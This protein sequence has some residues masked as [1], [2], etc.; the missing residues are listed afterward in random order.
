MTGNFVKIGDAVLSR[1][2][3]GKDYVDRKFAEAT[4][5][6]TGATGST[7][8]VKGLVPAP[9]AGDED[10]VLSGAGTWVPMSGGSS[11]DLSVIAPGYVEGSSYNRGQLVH[12]D[13]KLYRAPGPVSDDSWVAEH[14]AEVRVSDVVPSVIQS[15]SV[16]EASFTS[17]MVAMEDGDSVTVAFVPE[18]GNMG[19]LVAGSAI[20]ARKIVPANAGKTLAVNREGTGMELTPVLP[21][22]PV[23]GAT[24]GRKNGEWKAVVDVIPNTT[25]EPFVL[26]LDSNNRWMKQRVYG[27]FRDPIYSPFPVLDTLVSSDDRLYYY[28]GVL[29]VASNTNDGRYNLADS[30]GHTFNFI[31]ER[32]TGVAVLNGLLYVS[33]CTTTG[34]SGS[35]DCHLYEMSR[36]FTSCTSLYTQHNDSVS[37]S[38]GLWYLNVA[39]GKVFI[40]YGND[41]TG[42]GYYI[43]VYTPGKAGVSVVYT[44]LTS[45]ASIVFYYNG[46]YVVVDNNFI[47]ILNDDFSLYKKLTTNIGQ[48]SRALFNDNCIIFNDGTLYRVREDWSGQRYSP[49]PSGINVRGFC[50]YGVDGN[51]YIPAYNSSSREVFLYKVNSGLDLVETIRFTRISSACR[52]PIVVDSINQYNQAQADL[53]DLDETSPAF[54]RNVPDALRGEAKQLVFNPDQFQVEETEDQVQVSVVSGYS[55]SVVIT[56][57]TTSSGEVEAHVPNNSIVTLSDVGISKLDRLIVSKSGETE[58]LNA[59]VYTSLTPDVVMFGDTEVSPVLLPYAQSTASYKCPKLY[60]LNDFGY[61][62][63]GYPR[64]KVCGSIVVGSASYPYVRIGS[65][66]V[67]SVS[68]QYPIGTVGTD[69]YRP[70]TC[71]GNG[72]LY[73]WDTLFNADGT[74][75]DALASIVP[76]GWRVPTSGDVNALISYLGTTSDTFYGLR[77]EKYGSNYKGNNIYGFSGIP[78]GYYLN[79]ILTA[80]GQVSDFWTSTAASSSSAYWFGLPDANKT[81]LLATEPKTDGFQ[82]RLIKDV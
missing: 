16:D 58:I 60:D 34:N 38:D 12:R 49:L 72:Y 29:Y 66:Y 54:I 23:D 56:P 31:G 42:S 80:A 67:M 39:N 51:F 36:D 9:G 17:S 20:N 44:D 82:L 4:V 79:G 64:N 35:G 3:V 30:L 69:Y 45:Q 14:W 61:Y 63:V 53:H 52:H 50:A 68:I 73:K 21:E 25:R 76:S 71:D 33:T 57:Q 8:G 22:A 18:S 13:G 48:T 37:H 2:G 62:V 46:K 6:M 75:K 15:R 24:Y 5:P 59:R 43:A 10:K 81:L 32:P 55:T 40:T 77:S 65:F 47:H 74:Y 70:E 7:A 1:G 19:E 27:D 41:T 78:Y 26:Y 11:I 28:D